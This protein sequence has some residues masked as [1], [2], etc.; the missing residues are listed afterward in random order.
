M[1]R[2]FTLKATAANRATLEN[3]NLTNI[4]VDCAI[5][6]RTLETKCT[7]SHFFFSSLYHLNT[8]FYYYFYSYNIFC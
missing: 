7:G 3:K 2:S 6:H 4:A 5:H 8:Q 1:T